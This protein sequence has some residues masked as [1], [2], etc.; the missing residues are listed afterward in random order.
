M[1]VRYTSTHYPVPS[2]VKLS[3]E[4]KMTSEVD[5]ILY[6]LACTKAMNRMTGSICLDLC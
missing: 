3:R 2:E 6:S 5:M 1:K 4:L